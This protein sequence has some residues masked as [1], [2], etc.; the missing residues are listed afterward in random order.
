MGNWLRDAV[1][2]RR[3][4]ESLTPKIG[5]TTG[6]PLVKGYDTTTVGR[7]TTA[8]D[9]HNKPGA[10]DP[11]RPYN[12]MTAPGAYEEAYAEHGGAFFEQGEASQLYDEVGDTYDAP[13][14]GEQVSGDVANE[15]LRGTQ[16]SSYGQDFYEGLLGS[17]GTADP[18]MIEAAWKNMLGTSADLNPY[19][20][21][22]FQDSQ[23]QINAA[24]AA[25]GMYNSSG[26]MRSLTQAST[27]LNAQQAMDEAKYGLDRATAM[28]NLAVEGTRGKADWLTSMGDLAFGAADEKREYGEAAS[29]IAD[30]ASKG[31]LDR[32]KAK[33]DAAFGVDTTE[34]NRLALGMEAAHGAQDAREGRIMDVANFEA[35]M[36]EA[37]ARIYGEANAND[38][39]SGSDQVGAGMGAGED[40][41]RAAAEAAQARIQALLDGLRTGAQI[42][43]NT[44]TPTT[45]TPTTPTKP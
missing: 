42:Y 16:G 27:R 11:T 15:L 21:L 31:E 6:G 3:Y 19:Y 24:A 35:R 41:R 44:R 18:G 12:D 26:A 32:L 9:K 33:F 29:V 34:A 39:G 40:S 28:G 36:A 22:A 10:P 45:A 43:G 17:G 2:D 30:R 14:L 20:D 7:T 23:S 5:V 38:A 4:R 37:L 13:M 1:G 25:R 8:E